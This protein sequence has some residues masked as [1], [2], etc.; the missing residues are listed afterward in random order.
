M[1]KIIQIERQSIFL[2]GLDEDGVIWE[3]KPPTTTRDY[4]D[5]LIH[6]NAHWIKIIESPKE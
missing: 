1:S 6:L 4:N 3:F 5:D 2:L